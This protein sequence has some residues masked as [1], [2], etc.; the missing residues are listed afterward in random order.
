MKLARHGDAQELF[1]RESFP[2]AHAIWRGERYAEMVLERASYTVSGRTLFPVC[3][4]GLCR[5]WADVPYS[6]TAPETNN[7]RDFAADLLLVPEHA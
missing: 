1:S 5:G 7:R 6:P 4:A 2:M 3:C